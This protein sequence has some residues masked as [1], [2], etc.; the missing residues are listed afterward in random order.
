MRNYQLLGDLV[1]VPT[2]YQALWNIY[3]LR[4]HCDGISDTPIHAI[5]LPSFCTL[6]GAKRGDGTCMPKSSSALPVDVH[7][8]EL[9]ALTIGVLFFTRSHHPFKWNQDRAV[10]LFASHALVIPF[11]IALQFVHGIQIVSTSLQFCRGWFV[12]INTSSQI[13]P[14]PPRSTYCPVFITVY[15]SRSAL[16]AQLLRAYRTS[17]WPASGRKELLSLLY[18]AHLILKQHSRI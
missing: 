13:L 6:C 7:C 12:H 9:S 14:S 3:F 15:S 10:H 8:S 11:T 4:Q 2:Y 18:I 17:L 16:S 1:L 5:T